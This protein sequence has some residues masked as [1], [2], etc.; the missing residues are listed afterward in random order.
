MA[1][2]IDF[3]LA[4]KYKEHQLSELVKTEDLYK[5]ITQINLKNLFAI[6]HQEFNRLFR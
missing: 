5:D 1:I 6:L 3:F 4:Q 2:D